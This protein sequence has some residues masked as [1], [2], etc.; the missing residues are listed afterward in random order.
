MSNVKQL[1][2]SSLDTVI[3]GADHVSATSLFEILDSHPNVRK[4]THSYLG[5]KY[6]SI[7]LGSGQEVSCERSFPN[8]VVD[9]CWTVE[10]K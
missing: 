5:T 2:L 1:D 4:S 6:R 3:G 10:P 9:R 8:A 7:T